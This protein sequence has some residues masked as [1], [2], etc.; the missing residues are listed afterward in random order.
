MLWAGSAEPGAARTARLCHG[1]RTGLEVTEEPDP[2]AAGL[3]TGLSMEARAGWDSSPCP[4]SKGVNGTAAGAGGRR[5]PAKPGRSGSGTP[6]LDPAA[7]TH[8]QQGQRSHAW[9]RQWRSRLPAQPP[10][11][12]LHACPKGDPSPPAPRQPGA[13][14]RHNQRQAP[15]PAPRLPAKAS[16]QPQ[17]HNSSLLAATADR[18]QTPS[19]HRHLPPGLGAG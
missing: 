18:C 19:A 15:T 9:R 2:S 12:A 4:P 13:F 1:S 6:W 11:T 16:A 8:F 14:S 5:C 3:S 17:T 7:P 10:S